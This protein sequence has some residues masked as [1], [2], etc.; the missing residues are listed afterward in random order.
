MTAV[1]EHDGRLVRF[2]QRFLDFAGSYGL[3]P[4]VCH[5]YRPQ[6]KSWPNDP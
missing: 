6:T 4:R 2:N 5:P 3:V 1:T